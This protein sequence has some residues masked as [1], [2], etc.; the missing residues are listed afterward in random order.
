M[1]TMKQRWLFE[2]VPKGKRQHFKF[3]SGH[4]QGM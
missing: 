4:R 2:N 1:I 3:R